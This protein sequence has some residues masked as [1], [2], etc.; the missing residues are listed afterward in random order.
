MLVQGGAMSY[1]AYTEQATT[2]LRWDG[3]SLNMFLNRWHPVDPKAD[4]YNPSTQWIQGYYAN[5]GTNIDENSALNVQNNAYARLKSVE[6]GYS[7]PKIIINKIGIQKL[8]F[9]VNAYNLLTVTGVKGLDPEHPS[10]SYS[11][12]YPLSRTI[13]LGATITF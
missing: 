12:L 10:D 3:N 6:L 9:F 5:T 7:I 8:R 13:N 11:Y 1:V 4:P 2:P